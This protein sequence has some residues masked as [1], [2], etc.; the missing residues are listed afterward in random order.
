MIAFFSSQEGGPGGSPPP[1]LTLSYGKQ[2]RIWDS[3][4]GV[5]VGSMETRDASG[6]APSWQETELR[7]CGAAQT[8]GEGSGSAL[9]CKGARGRPRR[10]AGGARRGLRLQPIDAGAER[11][12]SGEREPT[13]A[14][15]S[16]R[17]KHRHRSTRPLP[18]LIAGSCR[19]FGGTEDTVRVH[20]L[21]RAEALYLPGRSFWA[22]SFVRRR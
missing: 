8:G 16:G 20:C 11:G 21:F 22:A 14:A 15:K 12:E 2:P 9:H 17:G 10:G 19:N 3:G 13:A 18:S 1:A 7:N 5:P 4:R 6:L